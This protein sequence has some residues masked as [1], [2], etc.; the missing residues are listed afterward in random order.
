MAMYLI[1]NADSIGVQISVRTYNMVLRRSLP[2]ADHNHK[3][4]ETI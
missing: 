4:E 3:A 2:S 1:S